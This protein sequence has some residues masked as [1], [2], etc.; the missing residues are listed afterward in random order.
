MDVDY[1][2]FKDATE[3]LTSRLEVEG[4]KVANTAE[5]LN[6]AYSVT[7]PKLE[8]LKPHQPWADTEFEDRISP[9]IQNP[10]NAWKT[11]PE[12]WEPMMETQH[13][14]A[15]LVAHR[16]SYTYNERML[17]QLGVILNELGL[18]PNSREAHLAIWNPSLDPPRI[19]RRRVPC[20]L[21]YQFLI[22]DG[23]LNMVYLQ[24]SCNFPKHFQDDVYLARKLQEWVAGKL[25]VVPGGFSHWIGSLHIFV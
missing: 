12:I 4:V 16:F 21:G 19:G 9:E 18:N 22:R 14:E 3:A 1:G 11:L 25:G 7:D 13:M 23:K 24:R 10:G 20:T 6:V 17:H 15:G 8:D 2:N 5:I